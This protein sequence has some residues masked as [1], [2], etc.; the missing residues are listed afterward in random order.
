M[1]CARNGALPKLTVSM[2]LLICGPILAADL[3][4]E[5]RYDFTAC[6]SGT[7]NPIAFSKTHTA[8]SYEFT[9]MA[10]AA[11]PGGFGDK[12]SFRC[13]GV[14]KVFDGKMTGTAVCEGVDPDGHKTLS[15]YEISGPSAMRTHVAG[16]GKYEGMTLN[17]DPAQM[18]GP[19]P[20]I[21][22]GTFQNCNRQTGSYK[23]KPMQ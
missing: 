10:R 16:T 8:F 1:L 7:S 5:G 11:Q 22:Q 17:S 6:W 19:F 23:L 13:I 18:L 4:P 15:S 3:P 9:G 21:K 20:T 14:N 12:S 2:L